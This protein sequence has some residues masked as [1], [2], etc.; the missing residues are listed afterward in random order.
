MLF[1]AGSA[2]VEA[3]VFSGQPVNRINQEMHDMLVRN[4]VAQVGRKEH[5]GVPIEIFE[6][7]S[8]DVF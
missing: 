5:R 4:S 2:V 6:S 1:I 3:K 8:H 7:Y